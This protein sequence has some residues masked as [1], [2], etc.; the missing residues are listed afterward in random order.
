MHNVVI[1]GAASGIGKHFA[2][3]LIA[4]GGYRVAVADINQAA[5]EALYA[6]K[7]HVQIFALDVRDPAA[8]QQLLAQVSDNWGELDYLFNIAGIIVPGY[9]HET[10]IEQIDRH[11]DINTKGV[12][13]GTKFAAE[14]MVKQHSGHIIN[15]ASLAGVAPIKGIS[16]YSA[17][18]FAVRGFTL[19]IAPELKPFGVHVTVFCPDLVDTPMLDAQL[20][21]PEAALT[22]SG[23]SKALT[24]DDISQ[25][26][27]DV[28]AKKPLEVTLPLHRGLLAKFANATPAAAQ[29]LTTTLTRKGRKQQEQFK[30]RRK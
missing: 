1:T 3:T 21:Y 12:I 25:A 23:S 14:R 16:L 18:K 13:Y 10:T 27:L 11:I 26:L 15:I 30:T 19:A 29:I 7:D 28:M 9:I 2:Q 20:E 5:L 8:W 22:F 24:V 17:S 4:R 6:T